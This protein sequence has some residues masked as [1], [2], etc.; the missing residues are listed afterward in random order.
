MFCLD[1]N[2]KLSKISYK[3]CKSCNGKVNTVNKVEVY[4]KFC[5]VMFQKLPWELRNN[6]G[7]YCSKSCRA[8]DL[9][10]G[11]SFSTKAQEKRAKQFGKSN[12]SWKGKGVGYGGLHAWISRRLGKPAHCVLCETTQ[13][14]F[15]WAN[16]S[17]QYL[18]DLGDWLRLCIS[19]HRRYDSAKRRRAVV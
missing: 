15:E 17:G 10:N 9:F 11:S 19:C 1:C 18:R 13:G 16:K 4:C 6:K 12:P 3:R 2:K 14:K 8:K 5:K 7:I